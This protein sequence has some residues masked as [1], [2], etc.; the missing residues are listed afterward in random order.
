MFIKLRID[1]E[2]SLALHVCNGRL[3][4][5]CQVTSLDIKRHDDDAT[6]TLFTGHVRAANSSVGDHT[7]DSRRDNLIEIM[8][9]C[10]KILNL[11]C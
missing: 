6:I 1:T 5:A 7:R 10:H 8:N 3:A 9:M 4:V 11:C 2:M